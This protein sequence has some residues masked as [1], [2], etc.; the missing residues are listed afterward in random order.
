VIVADTNLIAYFLI[1]GPYTRE[2]E[3]VYAKD[4]EW[5]APLIWRSEFRNLLVTRLRK[6]AIVLS[7]ALDLADEAEDLM[8]GHEH[9]TT[10]SEILH[11]AA[12]TGCSAYDCEFMALA[13]MLRVP[14]VTSDKGVLV[15]FRPTAVSMRGFCL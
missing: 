8:R 3:A 10:S 14:L 13:K 7:D 5:A 6:K 11:L 1:D 15:N 9:D 2:A 12:E 4:P